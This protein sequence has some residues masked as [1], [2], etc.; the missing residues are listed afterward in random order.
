MIFWSTFINH[1]N[2]IF[3]TVY[4][5]IF[6]RFSN[7]WSS[8]RYEMCRLLDYSLTYTNERMNV[9]SNVFV[10][11]FVISRSWVEW[12]ALWWMHHGLPS[13]PGAWRLYYDWCLCGSTIWGV[14]LVWIHYRYHLISI[15]ISA[16][17]LSWTLSCNSFTSSFESERSILL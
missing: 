7:F 11:S 14:N 6:Y 8:T 16:T 13:I 17:T 10:G 4:F 2:H 3:R 5:L 12:S 9:H 1:L 15:P